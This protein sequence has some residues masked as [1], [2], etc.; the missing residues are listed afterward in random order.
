MVDMLRLA[1][2]Y[3]FIAHEINIT[4]GSHWK[5]TQFDHCKDDISTASENNVSL[6]TIPF[7]TVVNTY[8][9]SVS[10]RQQELPLAF[11]S[12]FSI[13]VPVKNRFTSSP[14]PVKNNSKKQTEK[15][16]PKT[17]SS[18][19]TGGVIGREAHEWQEWRNFAGALS[20]DECT[21]Q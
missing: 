21:R 9:R 18:I 19:S 3:C 6:E 5:K 12:L 8:R 2:I 10:L 14:T 13:M 17:C 16:K 20:S 7:Q 11:H 4:I 1:L 15:A